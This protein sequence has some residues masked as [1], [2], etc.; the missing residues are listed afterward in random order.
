VNLWTR[1]ILN[2]KKHLLLAFIFSISIKSKNHKNIFTICNNNKIRKTPLPFSI[3][4]LFSFMLPSCILLFVILFYFVLL[5]SKPCAWQ[6]H[7]GVGAHDKELVLQVARHDLKKLTD[8]SPRVRYQTQ[9]HPCGE[10]S[11]ATSFCT[12]SPNKL[13]HLLS[14]IM[15]FKT[16]D[17]NIG[18]MGTPTRAHGIGTPSLY[19]GEAQEDWGS[20]GIQRII[21]I[22][23]NLCK[24]GGNRLSLRSCILPDQDSGTQPPIKGD[25]RSRRRNNINSTVNPNFVSI[26]FSDW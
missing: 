16:N 9:S 3:S 17:Y 7:C 1:S 23:K 22:R 8:C 25:G 5:I 24:E 19:S 18:D 6:L 21:C 13:A 14:I 15:Y 2:Y 26:I 20:G 12:W 11:L 4:V 10:N